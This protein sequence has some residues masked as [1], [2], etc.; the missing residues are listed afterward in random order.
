MIKIYHAPR[1]RSSRILWLAEELDVRYDVELVPIKRGDGTGEPAPDSYR[2]IHPHKKVPAIEHEG[3]IVYESAA[4]VMYLT[5]TFQRIKMGPSV[6]EWDRAPYVTWL[7]YYASVIEPAI[8]AHFLKIESAANGFVSWEDAEKRIAAALETGPYI[9]GE[10]FTGVDILI[11]SMVMFLKGSLMP[12]NKV[13]DD[14][15]ARL[16]ERPAF[17]R[18]QERDNG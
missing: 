7:F 4:I 2:A 12:A 9:M 13:Y 15:L 3:W 8:T 6:G 1:S 14:Y 16:V 18:A 17:K 5:D 11:G 10:R